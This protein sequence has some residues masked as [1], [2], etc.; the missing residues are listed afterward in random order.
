MINKPNTQTRS[1]NAGKQRPQFVVYGPADPYRGALE[2]YISAGYQRCYQATI[3]QP[4]PLL[5]SLNLSDGPQAVLGLRPAGSGR[6]F[7]ENYLDSAIESTIASAAAQPILR[8][9]IVEIGNLV[10]TG[11]TGSQ[12]LFIVMTAALAEAGFHWMTFTAT[13][14]VVK[15]IGRLGFTPLD[16]GA[17]KPERLADAGANWGSYYQTAP[18]IQAGLLSEAMFALQSNPTSAEQLELFRDTIVALA[19]QISAHPLIE[20]GL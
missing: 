10:A 2:R 20:Q 13:P 7:L 16:L 18:R 6:L 9:S 1:T 11:R 14:Q 8:E 5:L 17:A 19:R 15:L 12:Q 4:M 3:T